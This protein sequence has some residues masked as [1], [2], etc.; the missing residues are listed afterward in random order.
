MK[1]ER[2]EEEKKSISFVEQM[3]EKDLADGKE[4]GEENRSVMKFSYMKDNLNIS[5]SNGK[6]AKA[7]GKTVLQTFFKTVDFVHY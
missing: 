5:K 3:V 2:P 7:N 4:N 6:I 1:E